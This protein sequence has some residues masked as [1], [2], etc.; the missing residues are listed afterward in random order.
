MNLEFQEVEYFLDLHKWSIG[1]A[2]FHGLISGL[3]CAGAQDDDIDNWLP[4]LLDNGYLKNEEYRPI[5]RDVRSAFLTVRS[6]LNDDGFEYQILLP[7]DSHPIESRLDA[8]NLWCRGFLMTLKEYG[9][10]DADQLSVD[11]CEFVED[12]QSISDAQIE[13][14]DTQDDSEENLFAIQE[15]LRVGVQLVYEDLNPLDGG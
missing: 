4:V 9:E 11:C 1:A 14:D 7:D 12:V 2:E 8:L 13:V 10:V 5:K 15:Y 6:L 3:I